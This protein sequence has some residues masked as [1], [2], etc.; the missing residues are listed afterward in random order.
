[1]TIGKRG[2]GRAGLNSHHD[3]KS[4]PKETLSGGAKEEASSYHTLMTITR[5]LF[6]L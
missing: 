5:I 6:N 2:E 3:E 1:M 4:G